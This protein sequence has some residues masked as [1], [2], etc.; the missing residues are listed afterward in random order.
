MSLDVASVQTKYL[1]QDVLN[2]YTSKKIGLMYLQFDI[3]FL[4]RICVQG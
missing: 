1:T 2:R 3:Q 4:I